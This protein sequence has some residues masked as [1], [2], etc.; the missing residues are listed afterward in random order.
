MM[1]Y[2]FS[3]NFKKNYLKMRTK[4]ICSGINPDGSK[5]TNHSLRNSFYCY[6]HLS[7]ATEKDIERMERKRLIEVL[8]MFGVIIA[9]IIFCLLIDLR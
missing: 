8:S 6:S 4:S 1:S 3:V 7:Q 2:L 9:L 5:C